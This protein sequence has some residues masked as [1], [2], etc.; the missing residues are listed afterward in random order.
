[1]NNVPMT[2][3]EELLAIHDQSYGHSST[4]VELEDGR[5]LH[6][7]GTI[8]TT[9]DDGGITWSKPYQCVDTEGNPV[10]GSST[11]LVKLDGKGIGLAA[12]RT[13]HRK[14]ERH[15]AEM[16]FWRSP[17]GG[18]TWEPPVTVS[19]PG[20]ATYALQDVM[21]RTSSG[22]IILPIYI[23]IG[24]GG[25]RQE[26]APFVGAL[27]RGQFVST[28]AHFV[29]PHFGACGIYYSD[30]DGRTWQ[31]NRD[32]ELFIRLGWTGPFY[33][34]CEPT[35]AEVRPGKLLMIMRTNLGRLFQAWSEDNGETWTRPQPT[36][37]AASPAPAQLR[38]IPSTGHLLIAWTQQSEEEI[39]KGFIRTRLSSAISRN[40]GGVWEFYQN[41]ESLHEETRVEPGPIRP[42]CPEQR[43]MDVG[44]PALERRAEYVVDLPVGW[45]R[46]SYP[47]VFVYRDRVL[48]SYT[49]SYYEEHPTRAELVR[50]GPGG[51]NSR[52]KD[53]P[54]KWFYGGKEPA[55]NPQLSRTDEAAHP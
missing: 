24:Q 9:S 42:V 20:C 41:V 45:G 36:A 55:D 26:G 39:L 30:D 34:T 18:S 5:I 21:L 49:Y 27:I 15:Q 11:S 3:P 53:L 19:P 51:A 35:V 46:W 23:H 10:G 16:V 40:G 13:Y 54:L 44:M 2:R 43:F 37:L 33:P 7:A 25:V 4:F 50:T 17:D 6:V 47:S 52:L 31:R 1:M 48:I 28:D 22:R 29:D 12:C 8:F 38:T 32:G 14:G